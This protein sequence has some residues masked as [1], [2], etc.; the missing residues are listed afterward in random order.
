MAALHYHHSLVAKVFTSWKRW[1]SGCK[2]VRLRELTRHL[3]QEKMAALL[4]QVSAV[5]HDDP[6]PEEGQPHDDKVDELHQH[7]PHI[8]GKDCQPV[9]QDESS[10]M[11][12][13]DRHLYAVVKS[14]K[15]AHPTKSQNSVPSLIT[16]KLVRQELVSQVQQ[17][18]YIHALSL[19]QEKLL[20]DNKMVM[21][22][23]SQ[24]V[25]ETQVTH[26]GHSAS[27]K[28]A[29]R[30]ETTK[31]PTQTPSIDPYTE[32]QPSLLKQYHAVHKPVVIARQPPT[33][34][35]AMLGMERRAQ[36]MAERRQAR[37]DRKRQREEQ[38]LVGYCCKCLFYVLLS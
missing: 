4:A 22:S 27:N 17:D 3:Q 9:C 36:M 38:L 30:S 16:S 15:P 14:R 21:P 29:V 1:C 13:A 7:E 6:S 2:E 31:K 37:E 10:V 11:K 35:V 5:H 28:T 20:A 12:K 33:K 25:Q 19:Q 32:H 23:K 18:N 24:E 34:P 8:V 26:N